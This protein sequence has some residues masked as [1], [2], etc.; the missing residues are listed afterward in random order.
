MQ[1]LSFRFLSSF[2]AICT[3][4]LSCKT[5]PPSSTSTPPQAPQPPSVFQLGEHRFAVDEF[6]YAFQKKQQSEDSGRSLTAQAFLQQYATQKWKVLA[7]RESG[8]DTTEAFREEIA[9]YRQELAQD[10]LEDADL[11]SELI[12]EAYERLKT[13]VRASHILIP[14]GPFA[15]PADTLTAYN[16]TLALR[17]ELLE[18]RDFAEMARRFSKDTSTAPLGGDLGYFTAFKNVYPVESAAYMTPVGEISAPVRSRNGYHVL[19]IHDKRSTRGKLQ[20]AHLMVRATPNSTAASTMIQDL[21]QRL[22]AGADWTKLVEEYSE[23]LTTRTKGGM[24]A[25]FGTGEM[26]A[27]FEEVAFGLSRLGEY[28]KPFKTSYG[29]HIVRLEGQI[30]LPDYETML[31][32]LRL[33]VLTDTRGEALKKRVVEKAKANHTLTVNRDVLGQLLPVMTPNLIEGKWRIPTSLPPIA[34]SPLVQIEQKKYTVQAFWNFVEVRQ[35]PAPSKSDVRTLLDYYAQEFLAKSWRDYQID[36]LEKNSREF[37]FLMNEVREGVMLNNLLEKEVLARSLNDSLA[38]LRIY[39]QYKAGYLLPERAWIEQIQAK[40]TALL[41]QVLADKAQPLYPLRTRAQELLFEPNK[42]ELT[43]AHRNSLFEVVAILARNQAIQVEVSAFQAKNEAE[44]TSGAR[45]QNV[46]RF[47]QD[48]GISLTR[49]IEK[50]NGSYGGAVELQKQQSVGFVFYSTSQKD[51]EK[52][53]NEREANSVR[54]TEGYVNKQDYAFGDSAPWQ[55]GEYR[56]VGQ[57]KKAY[58]V[59]IIRIEPAREKT[60]QEA[61]GAVINTYQRQLEAALLDK[62]RSKHPISINE[63]EVTKIEK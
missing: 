56:F 33:K 53:Y 29:W 13:E 59:K 63:E 2:V 40:D 25:P 51:L 55:V 30:P 12:E 54:I 62:M 24:L 58:R 9:S 45:L 6:L 16:A 19:K 37:G 7:A 26:V 11:V 21:Y 49:I 41:A 47:L 48:Y 5:A 44:M 46:V 15:S 23:D 4:V 8:L 28:S 17:K 36:Q 35:K 20:V 60:F 57:D 27:E 38:Q 3:L 34:S 52:A 61:R 14:V 22:Q 1:S 50:D 39:E 31:P 42:K 18:G 10:F 43:L 32:S